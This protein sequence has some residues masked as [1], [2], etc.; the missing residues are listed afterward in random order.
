MLPSSGCLLVRQGN[1]LSFSPGVK[2]KCPKQ[3]AALTAIFL[4]PEHLAAQEKTRTA[5]KQSKIQERRSKLA[6]VKEA[7]VQLQLSGIMLP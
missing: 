7:I 6:A 1:Q 4:S 3:A 2:G 5:T